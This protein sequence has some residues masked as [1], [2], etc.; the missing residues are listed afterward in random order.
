MQRIP[1]TTMY[2]YGIERGNGFINVRN[3]GPHKWRLR[4]I[5]Q[6]WRNGEDY[7]FYRHW[8]QIEYGSRNQ[9]RKKWIAIVNRASEV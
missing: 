8:Q 6:R 2:Q 1:W 7:V 3:L 4:V 5:F 9:I